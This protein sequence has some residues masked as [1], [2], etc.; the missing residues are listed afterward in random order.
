M[1]AGFYNFLKTV[2]SFL[3]SIKGARAADRLSLYWRSLIC[4][5]S[6]VANHCF[7]ICLMSHSLLR[8]Q[9]VSLELPVVWLVTRLFLV[10]VWS[11][12]H[13]SR[14]V[15]N[16]SIF[17]IHWHIISQC[18]QDV[19]E[20]LEKRVK[21]RFSHRQIHMF[22]NMSFDSYTSLC[23]SFLSLGQSFSDK[24]FSENWDSQVKVIATSF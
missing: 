8:L 4:L 16:W 6:I 7:I 11:C 19:T 14:D 24:K 13:F 15:H 1:V 20:L 22:N 3:F 12:V 5:P 21:S 2:S 23:L 9:F 10:S 18:F 17:P